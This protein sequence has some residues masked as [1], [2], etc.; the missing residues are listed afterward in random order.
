MS[1]SLPDSTAPREDHTGLPSAAR[2]SKLSRENARGDSPILTASSPHAEILALASS[3]TP[4]RFF[5]QLHHVLRKSAR[6][7]SF[8]IAA[9]DQ[10]ANAFRCRYADV[11]G[12]P[13]HEPLVDTETAMRA[14]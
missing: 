11:A 6:V 3:L 9:F 13:A 7:S 4:D 1:L 12:R 2:R 5:A 8:S 14:L 10:R